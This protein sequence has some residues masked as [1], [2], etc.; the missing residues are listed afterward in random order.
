MVFIQF[1]WQLRYN[2]SGSMWLPKY[3]WEVAESQCVLLA[4]TGIKL[5]PVRGESAILKLYKRIDK[6]HLRLCVFAMN[7]FTIHFVLVILW[8]C[9]FNVVLLNAFIAL[10]CIEGYGIVFEQMYHDLVHI[11]ISIINGYNVL[12]A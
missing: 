11:L 6:H 12:A 5:K 2:F 4:S 1:L 3:V 9:P 10:F 8:H 7:T